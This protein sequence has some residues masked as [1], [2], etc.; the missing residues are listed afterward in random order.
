[1]FSVAQDS[2]FDRSENFLR[3]RMK[4]RRQTDQFEMSSTIDT[5]KKKNFSG[6]RAAGDQESRGVLTAL[7]DNGHFFNP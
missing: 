3:R 7:T 1:M 6:Q 4:L 5:D 2:L